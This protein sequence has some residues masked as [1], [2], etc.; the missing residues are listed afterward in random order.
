[1]ITYAT[2]VSVKRLAEN[3]YEAAFAYNQ[4]TYTKHFEIADG[5]GYDRIVIDDTD[6]EP[7]LPHSSN[8]TRALFA[9]HRAFKEVR[10][11]EHRS[12]TYM[13]LMHSAEN[14]ARVEKEKLNLLEQMMKLPKETQDTMVQMSKQR[15]SSEQHQAKKF[16][17]DPDTDI[18]HRPLA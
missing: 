4:R 10:P 12:D 13:A 11:V 9:F 2:L 15:A 3:R 7:L 8:T 1:M 6:L 17:I 5:G 16:W 14:L 18:L